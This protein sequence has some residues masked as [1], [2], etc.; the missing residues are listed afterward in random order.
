MATGFGSAIFTNFFLVVKV[1]VICVLI[2]QEA[3]GTKIPT[4]LF[5]SVNWRG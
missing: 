3:L 2:F 5:I 4:D 1:K